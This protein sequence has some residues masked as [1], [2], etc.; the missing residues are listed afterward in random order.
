MGGLP[1]APKPQH[2]GSLVPG[3]GL[4]ELRNVPGRHGLVLCGSHWWRED[5]QVLPLSWG[6]EVL[7]VGMS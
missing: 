2:T 7:L 4:Q 5:T 1:G 6:N 3:P